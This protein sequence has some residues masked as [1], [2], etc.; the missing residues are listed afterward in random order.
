MDLQK[1]QVLWLSLD[2]LKFWKRF[3][4]ISVVLLKSCTLESE[5]NGTYICSSEDC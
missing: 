3:L 5:A 2:T 1:I 4:F